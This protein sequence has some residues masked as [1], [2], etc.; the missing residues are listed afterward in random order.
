MTAHSRPASAH[1]HPSHCGH[2]AD[3]GALDG[4]LLVFG[5]P[6]SNL[7]ATRAVLDV[8][9][10]RGIAPERTICTGDVA[11][12]CADPEAT[13]ALLRKAGIPTVMGN[14]EES[15]G[16]G[17]D[18][19]GCNFEAD[20]AC[21]LLSRRWYAYADARISAA[22]RAWMRNLPRAIRFE[23]GGRRWLAVHGAPSRIN[24]WIFSSTCAGVKQAELD[25]AET[26]AI[27]A[28]HSG[29]PFVETVDDRLWLNAGSVGLPANDGTPRVWYALLTAVRGDIVVS[30]HPLDYDH[31]SAADAMRRAMLPEG[32]ARALETGLWPSVEVL[33]EAERAATGRPLPARQSLPWSGGVLTPS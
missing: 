31:G 4:E 6:V 5:G 17:A 1:P 3:L 13:A 27:L 15:F 30:I 24:G 16:A 25:L 19:C 26:D 22:S 20:S 21:D 12:Y 9:Q 7:Q 23:L 14:C 10:E 18:D 28:G 11:A 29:L 8:A 33:P 2:L 32:Y